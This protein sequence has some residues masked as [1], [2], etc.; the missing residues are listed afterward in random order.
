ML[1]WYDYYELEHALG[2]LPALAN[3]IQQAISWR[4]H[5]K[6]P[7]KEL[8]LEIFLR[9]LILKKRILQRKYD[10][11]RRE[12]KLVFSEKMNLQAKLLEKEMRLG[13]VERENL[14]IKDELE[15]LR[16]QVDNNFKENGRH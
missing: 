7:P 15:R 8:R 4:S 2:T 1:K 6:K 5:N 12:L 13:I 3:S 16:G 11:T 10:W 14:Y 9:R